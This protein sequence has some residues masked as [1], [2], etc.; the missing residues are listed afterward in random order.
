MSYEERVAQ[1][2]TSA[3]IFKPS[4]GPVLYRGHTYW[5]EGEDWLWGLDHETGMWTVQRAD[6]YFDLHPEL[7]MR[8]S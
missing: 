3:P 2:N 7:F 4:R 5:L 8:L 6:E 1:T